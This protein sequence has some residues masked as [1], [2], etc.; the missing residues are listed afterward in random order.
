MVLQ[1]E[2]HQLLLV[3]AAMSGAM[4]ALID[5]QDDELVL[6][7]LEPVSV[8]PERHWSRQHVDADHLHLIQRVRQRRSLNHR[9]Q[10]RLVLLGRRN[11]HR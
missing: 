8:G 6:R 10:S 9:R 2:E 11:P 5:L 1:L 7:S 3:V 4:L